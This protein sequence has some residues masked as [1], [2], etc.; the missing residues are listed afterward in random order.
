MFL[1]NI[2][3]RKIIFLWFAILSQIPIKSSVLFFVHISVFSPKKFHRE[4]NKLIINSYK[5][6][7]HTCF[8]FGDHKELSRNL[9]FY[10]TSSTNMTRILLVDM[11]YLTKHFLLLQFLTTK[12]NPITPRIF[13]KISSKIILHQ[14]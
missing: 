9:M 11:K 10:C 3:E 13:I 1:K 14:P 6:H 7:Y 2:R 5:R 8:V 4:L 12:S